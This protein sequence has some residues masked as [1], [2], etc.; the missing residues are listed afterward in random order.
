[1]NLTIGNILVP[2][3]QGQI[4]IFAAHKHCTYSKFVTLLRLITTNYDIDILS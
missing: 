1:M 4:K 2:I 3:Y